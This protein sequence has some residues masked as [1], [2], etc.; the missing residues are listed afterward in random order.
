MRHVGAARVCVALPHGLV[1][2]VAATRALREN[3]FFILFFIYLKTF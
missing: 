1:C 2:H 3:N